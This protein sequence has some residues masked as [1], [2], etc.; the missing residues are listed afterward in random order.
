MTLRIQRLMMKL[1]RYD[2]E[3]I[4][5]P[6]KYIV[7]A[8]ALSRAP[9]HCEPHNES[10]TEKD[11][12]LHV[13]LVFETLPVSDMKSEMIAAE[14]AKD[15]H[16]TSSPLYA[17]SNG[18]AEKGVHIVKQLLKKAKDCNA[19]PYL[20]LLSYRASPLEHGMSP[21][22]LLMRRKLRTTLPHIAGQKQS[23]FFKHL[24]SV[25]RQPVIDDKDTLKALGFEVLYEL[26]N[27]PH[28][29]H[30]YEV[31]EERNGLVHIVMEAA[32]SFLKKVIENGPLP[33]KTARQWFSQIVS[34]LDYMHEQDIVHRDLNC[35]N[36]LVTADSDVK[37]TDFG[38]SRVTKGYPE[39]CNTVCGTLR[40]PSPEVLKEKK[41]DAKKSDVWSL[42]IVLYQM[43]TEKLP[44]S[45]YKLKEL[46]NPKLPFPF[47]DDVEVE[48]SCR[49]LIK[50]M[51]QLDPS[52]RPT[53]REVSK[54]PWLQ[55]EVKDTPTSED[56]T[57]TSNESD[58]C[59]CPCEVF[60]ADLEDHSCGSSVG[61]LN[62]V[63]CSAVEDTEES[64]CGCFGRIPPF[65]T[66]AKRIAGAC[67]KAFRSLRRKVKRLFCLCTTAMGSCRRGSGMKTRARSGF[68]IWGG[69]RR[70]FLYFVCY[71]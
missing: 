47:A 44:S 22:E 27:H 38:L 15:E 57:V 48:E 58:M 37:I 35:H 41:Y 18:K 59:T 29:V 34:A 9:E 68:G 6:G 60:L 21:A 5:T 14:T 36:I 63:T 32:S 19:D 28:I 45:S 12:N 4:Y 25:M 56:H 17:Q 71:I 49:A 62:R 51:L 43:V 52:A 65:Q 54:H 7:L 61:S 50:D 33:N 42:G 69:V 13:N 66:A 8:D 2:F 1:Q 55:P 26:V 20:A 46:A 11:V 16:V 30:V 64:G 40:Y 70:G 24:F 31:I 23:R 67:A 53:V 39:L 3:L 10:S